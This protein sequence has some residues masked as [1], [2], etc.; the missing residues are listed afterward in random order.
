MSDPW[1]VPENAC[2]CGSTLLPRR[3]GHRMILQPCPLFLRVLFEW[4]DLV[5]RRDFGLE[6][7][8]I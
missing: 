3:R 5:W 1:F 2:S 7:E 6:T 8:F 4:R